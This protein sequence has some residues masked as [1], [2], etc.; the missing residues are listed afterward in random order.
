MLSES[1]LTVLSYLSTAASESLI[2][3]ELADE[4][5]WD[6]GH[7]SRVVSRLVESG[8]LVRKKQNGRYSVSL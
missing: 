2:Q 7:T 4:L 8:L 5:E 1:E 6:P 3:R